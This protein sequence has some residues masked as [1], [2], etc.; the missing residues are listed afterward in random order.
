[1]DNGGHRQPPAHHPESRREERPA[2]TDRRR[3]GGER[4]AGQTTPEPARRHDEGFDFVR[5][6]IH[7]TY[8]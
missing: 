2:A 3:D 4:P 7:R 6:A 5:S 1:M 8:K